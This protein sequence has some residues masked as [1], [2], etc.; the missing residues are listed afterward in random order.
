MY[1]LLQTTGIKAKRWSIWHNGNEIVRSLSKKAAMQLLNHLQEQNERKASLS[2][3]TTER[4]ST[5]TARARED[6]EGTTR[7]EADWR[8]SDSTKRGTIQEK[9]RDNSFF[10]EY[11]NTQRERNENIARIKRLNR[12]RVGVSAK[13]NESL[14]GL[15]RNVIGL[16]RSTGTTS[17]T[18]AFSQNHKIRLEPQTIDVEH[19][20]TTN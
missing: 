13:V 7:E 9:E 3:T 18:E 10:D 5:E 17:E 2:N 20:E 1:E 11:A 19:Y 4:A 12:E 6:R 14:V 16:V 8:V 15:S